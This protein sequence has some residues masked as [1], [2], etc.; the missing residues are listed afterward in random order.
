MRLHPIVTVY[1][2]Q[3]QQT[4]RS[5]KDFHR[6]NCSGIMSK[7]HSAA[8]FIAK[9]FISLGHI[10][11]LL[12]SVA[13][14]LSTHLAAQAQ[15]RL[16]VRAWGNN[17][18][19]QIGDG[20]D[21]A[22]YLPISSHTPADMRA[23]SAGWQHSLAL[24]ADGDVWA[25]GR[26]VWGELG[27][28]TRELP[29]VGVRQASHT[30]NNKTESTVDVTCK[31]IE[32]GQFAGSEPG[33]CTVPILV[34][35]LDQVIAIAAGPDTSF[36]IRKDGTLWNWGV[37]SRQP[38]EGGSY[39]FSAIPV[40]IK[41]VNHVIAVASGAT[42]TLA[43]S[44]DGTV[45]AWGS[46][47]WGELG[48]GTCT[49]AGQEKPMPVSG[50]SHITA[51][52]AGYGHSAA[53]SSDGK[54]WTWGYNAYGE[55]GDG[56]H[57]NQPVPIAVKG[58]T[59][60]QAISAGECHSL[61]LIRS[62]AGDSPADNKVLNKTVHAEGARANGEVAYK[63]YYE[64]DS[65][66]WSHLAD[67]ELRG[68]DVIPLYQDKYYELVKREQY[69]L[70]IQRGLDYSVFGK[71]GAEGAHFPVDD[72]QRIGH[73]RRGGRKTLW[74]EE[75]QLLLSLLR[76]YKPDVEA[77]WQKTNRDPGELVE[78]QER[79]TALSRQPMALD[80]PIASLKMTN[81]PVEDVYK[82]LVQNYH[83]PL[84]LIE[85]NADTHVS[86]DVQAGT[87]R[88]V[89][90]Q[91]TTQAASYQLKTVHGRLILMPDEARFQML[92]TEPTFTDVPR[93]EA[94]D[95]YCN[96]LSKN[97]A[98]FAGLTA[99]T[100]IMGDAHA[101]ILTEPITLHGKTTV[102]ERFMQLLG[103]DPRACFYIHRHT[104]LANGNISLFYINLAPSAVWMT[105]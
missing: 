91:I 68:N 85:T 58:L 101:P 43:L 6:N 39:T 60:A 88:D 89:L 33:D 16:I 73:S 5:L 48:N 97:I 95:R 9:K 24:K 2:I 81:V 77:L 66:H 55:L 69:A 44:A 64:V 47:G 70:D 35:G 18:S 4:K 82:E 15:D 84:S 75:A 7:G 52:A 30:Q 19:G 71:P 28:G 72:P 83:V 11:P 49:L 98:E 96:Y 87:A 105:R 90:A 20:N 34:E 67:Q 37:I 78:A 21:K 100:F 45:W 74:P 3:A 56:T 57:M 8:G 102:L 25:W 46:N 59:C 26:N 54:V 27:T 86:I 38:S 14:L 10:M 31:G 99:P 61:A 76:E 94:K 23:I 53:L 36:A 17:S 50:L 42:H 65:F 62:D 40:Q 104:R 93:V 92:L 63:T 12:G 13:M 103:K 32:R 22:Q 29:L 51:I 80:T 1:L 41:E 79:L